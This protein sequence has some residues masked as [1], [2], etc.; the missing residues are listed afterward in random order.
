MGATWVL[1]KKT[2]EETDSADP[3][4]VFAQEV[5]AT[6]RAGVPRFARNGSGNHSVEGEPI[7]RI[8]RRLS[9]DEAPE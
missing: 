8:P 6:I 9:E 3:R 4:K 5:F 7:G 2:W 1:G